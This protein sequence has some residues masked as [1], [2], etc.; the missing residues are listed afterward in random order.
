MPRLKDPS[1]PHALSCSQPPARVGSKLCIREID[2]HDFEKVAEL[3]G[4]RIG[5]PASYFLELL[6]RMAKLPVVV[7]FPRY[8]RVL[9]CDGTIVG[10]IILILSTR[11]CEAGQAIQCHVTGWAVE[12]AFKPLGA[13]FFA[14]DLAH[15]EVTYLNL[16]ARS[17]PHTM[18]II[19]VQRFIRYCDGR[20]FSVP[21]VK[22]SAPR[23]HKTTIVGGERE[24]NAPFEASDKHLLLDHVLFGCISLWCV[25][26]ERAYPFV[27]RPCLFKRILPG[28]QL[29]YCRD[30]ADFVRFAGPIG[31]HLA[32]RG[33][34]VVR[35]DANGPIPGLI[36]VYQHDVECRYYKGPKPRFGDLAYTHLAMCDRVPRK[37]LAE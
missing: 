7:G 11:R 36:G 15:E 17:S 37:K 33:R 35:I 21:A 1:Y 24:P 8:G 32:R 14:R 3:L 27:F 25:T 22:L 10:A 20:F 16:S 29:I 9:V 30:I 26:P 4:R 5:Y 6:Q 28:V 31:R 13:L 34:Y 2:E 18:P 23:N 19:E 12:R